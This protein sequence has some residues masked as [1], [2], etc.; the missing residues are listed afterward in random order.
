MKSDVMEGKR[1]TSSTTKLFEA[2]KDSRSLPGTVV[3][4]K[5][6][7]TSNNETS[8]QDRRQQQIERRPRTLPAVQLS[9]NGGIRIDFR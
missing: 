2:P 9:N 1:T 3:Q 8:E 6:Q 7:H 5:Q 4:S